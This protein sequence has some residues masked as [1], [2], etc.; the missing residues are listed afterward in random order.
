MDYDRVETPPDGSLITSDT[1]A[2]KHLL[3]RATLP[4]TIDLLLCDP[5]FLSAFLSALADRVHANNV[6]A[7]WWSDLNTGEDL[8]GKRNIAELLCL[9]HSEVSEAMEAHRKKLPDDKL[10]HRPGFKVELIDAIIRILDLLGSEGNSDHPAGV[11]F[12]EK[13]AYN[14]SREDHK[15]ENR[16]KEGGKAF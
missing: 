11:I 3:E 14:R 12:I 13:M 10:T 9:V 16:R 6:K 5:G 15:P 8:H 2:V 1:I 4:R 7:G